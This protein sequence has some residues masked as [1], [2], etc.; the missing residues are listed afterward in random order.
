MTKEQYDADVTE[1]NQMSVRAAEEFWMTTAVLGMKSS[2][3]D[4]NEECDEEDVVSIE[5]VKEIILDVLKDTIKNF[6]IYLKD[7]GYVY[8][9]H[10]ITDIR[11][12]TDFDD[13]GEHENFMSHTVG[14]LRVEGLPNHIKALKNIVEFLEADMGGRNFG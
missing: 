6:K 14:L 9:K 10:E 4:S 11:N 3:L 12:I 5:S 1:M 2:L 13:N 7:G 8:E